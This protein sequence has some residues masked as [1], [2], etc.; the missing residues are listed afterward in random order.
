MTALTL[1]RNLVAAL[2]A[3]GRRGGHA[4]RPEQAGRS[5]R[6]RSSRPTST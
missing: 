1:A 4:I 6:S 3:L 2:A 5:P